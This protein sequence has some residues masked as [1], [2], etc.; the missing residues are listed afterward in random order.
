MAR[1]KQ[2]EFVKGMGT[3]FEIIQALSSAVA[4][5]GGDDSDL[6]RVLS[7]KTLRDKIAGTLARKRVPGLVQVDSSMDLRAM[8]NALGP[9]VIPEA[10]LFFGNK[11]YKVLD[12]GIYD[13]VVELFPVGA[14][15]TTKEIRE[16]NIER[17]YREA[18]PEELLAYCAAHPE[19]LDEG[20]NVIGSMIFCLGGEW[21]PRGYPQ[22]LSVEKSNRISVGLAQAQP[23][24]KWTPMSSNL[25]NFR[26]AVV[27]RAVK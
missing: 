19:A 5:L 17:G 21:T 15:M 11:V 27:R 12:R 23:D 18:L 13:V 10:D 25:P 1:R 14:T 9:D 6:R 20:R 4:D 2:S 26:V 7:N 8:V 24:R 3:G 22:V 16:T